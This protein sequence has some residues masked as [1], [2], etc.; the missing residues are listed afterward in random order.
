MYAPPPGY[1]PYLAPPHAPT[2]RKN[3]RL[4]IAFG[5]IAAL[6][7][8]A[9]VGAL[10]VLLSSNRDT[11]SPAKVAPAT[12]TPT[13]AEQVILNDPLTANTYGWLTNDNCFFKAD[14]YHIKGTYG[15]YAPT[16]IDDINDSDTTVTVKMASVNGSNASGV[17]LRI[18]H[19]ENLQKN[20]SYVFTIASEGEWS[21]Q[22]CVAT[23]DFVVNYTSNAAIH[24]GVGSVNTMRVVAVGSHFTFYVN[25][26][27]VGQATDA[28]LTTGRIALSVS[29]DN[30]SVFTNLV[31]NQVGPH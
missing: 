14:G 27:K 4:F 5:I 12:A 30:Q 6:I 21:F 7:I 23:C 25:G 8:V 2:K 24:P 16:A 19:N 22:R 3:T 26:T 17:A 9:S 15:C 1:P 20:Q 18:T 10:A 11:N 31:I 29:G 28:T 13:V